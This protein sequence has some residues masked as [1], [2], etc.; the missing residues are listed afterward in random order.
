MTAEASS[1]KMSCSTL[2]VANVPCI[3]TIVG[4]FDTLNCMYQA[5]TIN[6]CFLFPRVAVALQDRIPILILL[7]K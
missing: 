4:L 5:V 2:S 6:G 7:V 3:I 1:F